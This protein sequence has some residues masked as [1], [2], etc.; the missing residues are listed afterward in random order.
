MVAN[1]YNLFLYP[2]YGFPE[3]YSEIRNI[4]NSTCIVKTPHYIQGW[5]NYNKLGQNLGWHRHWSG[6]TNNS[7]HGVFCVDVKDSKTTYQYIDNQ[8]IEEVYCEDNLLV[9]ANSNNNL[10]KTSDW[11][12]ETPRITIAFDIHPI[13]N[14]QNRLWI[15]HWTPL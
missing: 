15:N 14:L 7:I 9:M 1:S 13:E 5:L 11:N 6:V 10:H 12:Y 4:F 8:Q 3:L 2:F